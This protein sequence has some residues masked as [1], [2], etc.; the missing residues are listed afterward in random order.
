MNTEK[1]LDIISNWRKTWCTKSKH[2]SIMGCATEKETIN[3]AIDKAHQPSVQ[4]GLKLENG[5]STKAPRQE[6]KKYLSEE[7][8]GILH[9][10]DFTFEDYN[11][12]AEK[13]CEKI[14]KSYRD[15]G[16]TDYTYGNA[17]KLLSMTIKYVLSADNIDC[18]L[19]IFEIA[20]IP[21]DGVIMK[22]AKKELNVK[23]MPNAWSKTDNFAD[24]STYED[25]LRN[26]MP[27]GYCPLMWECEN[28][29]A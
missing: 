29:K 28:W 26:A 17:Q 13:V 24:I 19:H 5:Q 4:R 22:I 18:T 10:E 23:P 25:R 27:V 8:I 6:V 7:I 9:K 2:L 20:Y 15:H 21:I 16:I 3:L 1:Y 11:N 14:R 12:W